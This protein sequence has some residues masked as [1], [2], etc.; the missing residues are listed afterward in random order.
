MTV[1]DG[2]GPARGHSRTTDFTTGEISV[3][4]PGAVHLRAFVS[5]AEAVEVRYLE[6]PDA[7]VTLSGGLPG[8]PPEARYEHAAYA[9]QGL[10][11]PRARGRYPAGLGANGFE[12]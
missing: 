10:T 8:R 4:R 7:V 3:P 12:A 11:F 2:P 5:R 6:H 9:K 1:T